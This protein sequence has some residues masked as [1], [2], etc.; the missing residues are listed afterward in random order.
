MS[1]YTQIV[2]SLQNRKTIFLKKESI[3]NNLKKT[4][5][6]RTSIDQSIN[7]K[8]QSYKYLQIKFSK[9][10][11]LIHFEAMKSTFVDVDVSKK[12]FKI[13]IFYV[14]SDSKKNDIII[15]KNEIQSIMFLNK[16]LIDA[17]T[18]YWS[19]KLKMIEMIWIVKKIR[20][21]IE[22]C[23]KP[24]IIIFID[25]AIIVG[26]IKQTSLTTI[27]TDKLNLRLIRTSQFLFVL[28]IK[29]KVKSEKF[30][31]IFDVL[32]CLKTNPDPKKVKDK[33]PNRK[34]RETVVLKNLN[35]VEDLFAHAW[36][37]RHRPL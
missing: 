32:F 1:Y 12:N 24:S 22:S 33:S 27:N 15:I 29:I 31:V 20:H 7:A 37:L 13:M 14:Q 30:H 18:R 21:M 23:R 36:R 17:E 25:H 3:K 8:Y 16:I 5:S 26:L 28:S 10:S 11:F 9:S 2:E 6:K 4:F 19:T 35:D 34:S